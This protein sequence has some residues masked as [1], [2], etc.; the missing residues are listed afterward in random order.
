V[1]A[2]EARLEEL[3]K[4]V[5]TPF[6]NGVAI[7]GDFFAGAVSDLDALD[8]GFTKVWAEWV[9]GYMY[10]RGVLDERT[11]CIIAISE[12]LASNQDQQLVNHVKSAIK[13]GWEPREILEV[14]LLSCV[15]LGMPRMGAG[16]K[17]F[18]MA[19]EELDIAWWDE[20]PFSAPGIGL[21]NIA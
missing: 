21:S 15:Y 11:R 9:Y 16:L 5:G 2:R 12:C 4:K 1:T 18:R 7:Q 8:E 13:A 17:R 20:N 19:L 3:S 10:Q 14:F 6:D